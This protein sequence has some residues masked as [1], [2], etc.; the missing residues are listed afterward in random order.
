MN[1]L[2]INEIIGNIEKR[3]DDHRLV[4]NNERNQH[5]FVKRTRE[6]ARAG[7]AGR[8]FAV[9]ATEVKNWPRKPPT[10]PRR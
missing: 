4:N 10:P 1:Q 6:A 5:S 7:N 9:V 2:N 8:G 3:I